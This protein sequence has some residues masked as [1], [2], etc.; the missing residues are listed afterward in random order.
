MIK[1]KVI[2]RGE[3]GVEGG[4]T[5]K[6]YA[7]VVN[8]NRIDLKELCTEIERISTVNR[9]DI[10]AVLTALVQII[11]EKLANSTI[12]QLG[13]LGFFRTSLSSEG[14][15]TAEEVTKACIK[16]NRV[17]FTPG[18]DIKKVLA[19]AEYKQTSDG[20]EA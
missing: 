4:G 10:W 20:N 19:V 6:F 11:P 12:I 18:K 15:P 3:P 1:F 16:S 13:D 17:I 2:S 14:K 7:T 9:A 8:D 5:K